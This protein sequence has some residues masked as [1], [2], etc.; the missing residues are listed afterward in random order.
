MNR[1]EFYRQRILF[2][3]GFLLVMLFS[4]C[5]KKGTDPEPEGSRPFV[6]E[7]LGV[8]FGPWNRDTN[9]AGDFY[10]TSSLT[11]IMN[12]FGTEALDPQGNIKILPTMDFY[13]SEDAPVL[14]VSEGKVVRL[15]YQEENNDYEFSI[16]SLNDPDFDIVYD[17]LTDLEIGLEDSVQPGDTLGH[18]RPL[19]G[20][21]GFVEIMVNNSETGLSY[22]PFVFFNQETRPLYIQK[23]TQL[24]EDWET[25]KGDTTIYNQQ[26]HIISGCRIESI[27]TY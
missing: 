26:N 14:A 23:V 12:A 7:N 18:P 2:I 8:R 19:Y 21:I 6:I 24:M 13:I 3:T 9:L 1:S 25:F 15:V 22:C 17:H 16:Q 4:V 11:R 20:Q 5:E 10:F 27:V